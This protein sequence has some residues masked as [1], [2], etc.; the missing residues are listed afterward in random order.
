[1][2]WRQGKVAGS[3]KAANIATVDGLVREAVL[4]PGLA[5]VLLS[6]VTPD[7]APNVGRA[8]AATLRRSV[9]MGAASGAGQTDRATSPSTSPS[10]RNTPA[11][12]VPMNA[13][14]GIASGQPSSPS[15]HA[16]SGMGR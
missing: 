10:I 3:L 9:V 13:L 15:W 8:L 1:M 6:K 16:L 5:R 2:V 14:S 12:T 7:T 11:P 4:N